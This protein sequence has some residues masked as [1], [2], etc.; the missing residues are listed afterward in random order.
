MPTPS[1]YNT[2]TA[3]V[4][5]SG[6]AVTG[7]GTAWLN[8]IRPGD[9][10]GTHKG[11]GI[12][13]A[14]VN[15]NT[16]LTLAYAWLGGAQ[17]ALPYEIQITPDSA[18]MQET[19]R[20]LLEQLTNGNL[21]ALAGLSWSA[22]KLIRI[23]GA[24]AADL[25]DSK[26]IASLAGLTGAADRVPYFTAAGAMT[27]TP[28][29][30]AARS[31]M[32]DTTV[33]AMR[34]TIGGTSGLG[35]IATTATDLNAI[36]SNGWYISASPFTNAPTAA[37]YLVEH[38]QSSTATAFQRAH[39]NGNTYYRR[40]ASSVWSAWALDGGLI[41]LTVRVTSGTHTFNPLANTALI[42][43]IGAGGA[44]GNGSVASTTNASAG[45]GGGSGAVVMS[46]ISLAGVT[47]VACVIGAGGTGAGGTTT[48]IQS[49]II[50]LNAAGGGAGTNGVDSGVIGIVA[51]GSPGSASGGDINISGEAGGSGWSQGSTVA[52]TFNTMGGNGGSTPYGNGGA[53]AVSR[54]SPSGGANGSAAPTGFG[55]GGGGGVRFGFAATNAGGNGAGGGVIIMEYR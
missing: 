33:G 10:F 44:G 3:T 9:L 45:G 15:S 23:T 52:S 14:S 1:F 24:G 36:T 22:D 32:D 38:V 5:A 27:L 28:M 2:G 8:S 25:I 39:L 54:G 7:Q 20:L 55:G 4:A 40:K 26:N 18:R 37:F 49:G 11:A 31:V 47:S 42:I 21:S 6:T 34:D 48:V 41:A 50:N 30:E 17:T 19:T 29:T 46:N 43:G 16:S 35:A 53:G 13:I 12:R 51:G